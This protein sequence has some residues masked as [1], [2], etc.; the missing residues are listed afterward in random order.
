M[1]GTHGWDETTLTVVRGLWAMVIGTV[2]I[3]A[4]IFFV[5][6][7]MMEDGELV[8]DEIWVLTGMVVLAFVMA[9]PHHVMQLIGALVSAWRE[10]RKKT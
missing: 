1:S 9:L 8:Q 3:G 5:F 4:A 6:P 7:H 2:L 10:W